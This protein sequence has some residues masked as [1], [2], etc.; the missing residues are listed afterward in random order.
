MGDFQLSY[1]LRSSLQVFAG[2][3]HSND[4]STHYRFSAELMPLRGNTFQ[5]A[6]RLG[7]SMQLLWATLQQNN[8]KTEYT[9][10]PS[11]QIHLQLQLK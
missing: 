9:T 6:R 8:M 7:I 3:A 1:K 2:S 10:E 4:V 5:A 11:F